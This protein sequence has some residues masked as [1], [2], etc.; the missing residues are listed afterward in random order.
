MLTY[1]NRYLFRLGVDFTRIND[2]GQGCLHKASQ[3]GNSEFCKW[4]LGTP[5]L[6]L[7]PEHFRPNK[8]EKSAPSELALYTGNDELSKWLKEKEM[9]YMLK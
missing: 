5:G 6:V 8:A 1:S 3:R 2:N 9:P 4:L 7:G